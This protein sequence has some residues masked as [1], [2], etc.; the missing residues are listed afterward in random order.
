MTASKDF[1]SLKKIMAQSIIVVAILVIPTTVGSMIFSTSIISMLFA[2]GDFSNEALK[3]TSNAFFYY[4][5]GMIGFGL[6]DIISRVFYALQDSR[7]PAINAGIGMLINIILNIILSK[8]L[9]LGGL[10]LATSISAIVTTILLLKSL[11]KK[12]GPFGMKQISI[13]LLKILFA[14][15][16]MGGLAKLSFNYL[17][18]SLSQNLSLLLAIG[19]GAVSYFVIIYFMK[20]EDVDVIVSAVKKKLGRGTSKG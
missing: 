11:R 19:V 20:I 1:N 10:A 8:Y 2:R 16:V 6:R 12:M 5:I 13:S 9:G 3:M 14:S 18:A 15:L 4:S 17:T 7:K